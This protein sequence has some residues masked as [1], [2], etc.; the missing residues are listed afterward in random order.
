M[1]SGLR[2]LCT[3]YRLQA[4]VQQTRPGRSTRWT[5]EFVSL[6]ALHPQPHP[7]TPDHTRPHL[8]QRQPA[9]VRTC[10]DYIVHI[11]RI[12]TDMTFVV[13]YRLIR[14]P[15]LLPISCIT[16]GEVVHSLCTEGS[17]SDKSFPPRNKVAHAA[18][19][20]QKRA[21]CVA[22]MKD[23]RIRSSKRSNPWQCEIVLSDWTRL[24]ND[25]IRFLPLPIREPPFE[26]AGYGRPDSVIKTKP[27]V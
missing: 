7:T 18:C 11:V 6:D 24:P 15:Y 25:G 4:T 3:Q 5:G 1:Y 27:V 23:V 2:A 22:S 20:S 19:Q 13:L 12:R 14:N 10:T 16:K 26:R 21:L 9:I 17:P 8:P